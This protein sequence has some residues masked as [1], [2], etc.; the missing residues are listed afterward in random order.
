[1]PPTSRARGGIWRRSNNAD[2]SSSLASDVTAQNGC[3][4]IGFQA[5]Q[6]YPHILVCFDEKG[7]MI[8]NKAILR[9]AL[10][11][12]AL[13]VGMGIGY[14]LAAQPHMQAAIGFLQDARRQLQAADPDK[15]GHREAAIGLVDQAI[16]EVRAGMAFA[17]G[18]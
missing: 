5:W 12:A 9:K 15:G 3:G 6:G 17:N 4:G 1:V 11:P 8:M 14:A 18:G 10:V 2:Q 13:V 16:G 7:R